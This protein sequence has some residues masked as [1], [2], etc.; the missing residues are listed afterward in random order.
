MKKK[1]D[2][3]KAEEANARVVSAQRPE[4]LSSRVPPQ[5][6]LAPS[7]GGYGGVQNENSRGKWS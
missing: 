5:V 1:K 4:S 6:S 2:G 3:Q 7:Q